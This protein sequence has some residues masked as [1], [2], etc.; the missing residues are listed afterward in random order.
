MLSHVVFLV[1]QIPLLVA[2]PSLITSHNILFM[3]FRRPASS[4]Q[5]S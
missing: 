1:P 3:S 4:E 5:L 2:T